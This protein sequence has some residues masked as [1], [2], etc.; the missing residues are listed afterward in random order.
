MEAENASGAAQKIP[1]TPPIGP[2]YQSDRNNQSVQ[3]GF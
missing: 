2:L 1:V 3:V